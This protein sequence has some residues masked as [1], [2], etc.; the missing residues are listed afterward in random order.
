MSKLVYFIVFTVIVEFLALA[1]LQ[2]LFE[3]KRK[4]RRFVL[5]YVVIA[6]VILV[7]EGILY[8]VISKSKQ[9]DY[10][11]FRTYF[12]IT[13]VILLNMAPKL[14]LS[15]FSI[16]YYVVV[17]F[18]FFLKSVFGLTGKTKTMIKIK[19]LFIYT[20]IVLS[21][22]LFVNILYGIIK[23][24]DELSINHV[25]IVSDRLPES[26]DGFKIIQISDM[27]LGSFKNTQLVEKGMAAVAL[28]KPDLVVFTGDMVNNVA[29][30]AKPFVKFFQKLTPPFGM[31]TILGNHDMGDYRRWYK[32]GDKETNLVELQRLQKEMGFVMLRNTHAYIVKGNDSI[33]LIGVDN[34]GEPPFKKYGDLKKAMLGIDTHLFSI[35]LSHDPSHWI[36]EV[37]DK[38]HIDLTLSG[39]T[40]GFQFVFNLG[41]FRF[42]PVQW[43]YKQWGG[44]Y[45]H[46]KQCLYVNT[47][48]GFIGF[49]GRVGVNPEITVFTLRTD[50]ATKTQRH[51]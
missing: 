41:N 47:G 40:H 19:H 3:N 1:L 16:V 14:I 11:Q 10:I 28:Q 5:L 45:Q 31:Y 49:P 29:D 37:V 25:E 18:K 13:A 17:F 15:I 23:G 44:L 24:V 43:K 34:W 50:L 21:V 2:A 32:E 35:L 38:T 48:F 46:N 9:P 22:L 26:F 42:S 33:A 20:S 39:H 51:Q 27:H 12:N 7:L 30:E 4:K 36:Q 8:L 6:F